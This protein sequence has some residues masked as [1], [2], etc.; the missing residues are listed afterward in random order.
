[1]AGADLRLE[2]EPACWYLTPDLA[3]TLRISLRIHQ[4]G[5]GLFRASGNPQRT[6]PMRDGPRLPGDCLSE[7]VVVE[8]NWLCAQA[9]LAAMLVLPAL[10]AQTDANHWVL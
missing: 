4:H 7:I 10:F 8:P 5:W 2:V 3:A 9:E 6:T 1:M